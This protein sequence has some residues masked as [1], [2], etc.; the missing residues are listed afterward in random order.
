[1]LRVLLPLIAFAALALPACAEQADQPAAPGVKADL[2]AILEQ[3]IATPVDGILSAGQPNEEALQVFADSGFVA[4]IDLRAERENRGMEDEAAVVEGLGMKYISLPIDGAEAV[5]FENATS[6]SEVLAG[7][8][9]PV[10]VHC[11]SANRVGALLAL[12]KV[13]DGA[14]PEE[15]IAFGKSAGMTRLEQRVREV[16]ESA[17]QVDEL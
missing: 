15:A 6:L 17:D 5:N 7:F 9:E 12:G 13:Q 10:L 11:G 4:V 16:L 1:M 3:G 2:G 14:D 8:D